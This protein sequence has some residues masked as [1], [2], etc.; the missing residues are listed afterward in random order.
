MKSK[1]MVL[2]LTVSLMTAVLGMSMA[3][4]DPVVDPCARTSVSPFGGTYT[5]SSTYSVNGVAACGS[6]YYSPFGFSGFG[7]LGFGLSPFGIM[8]FPNF[9]F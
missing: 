1:N 2:I 5:Y 9:F 6:P 3:A 8:G 4:A 7:R